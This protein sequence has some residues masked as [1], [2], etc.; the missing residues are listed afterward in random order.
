M[1][2]TLLYFASVREATGCASETIEQDEG[3]SVKAVKQWLRGRYPSLDTLV[4]TMRIAMDEEFVS[5]DA[6]L[7]DGCEIAF[8]PPV[9][10]GIGCRAA[11]THHPITS[12][13]AQEMLSIQGAG[14]VI[15]FTGVVRPTSK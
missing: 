8:I 10:G 4:T 7:T 9:S 12:A 14:A 1:K 15:T 6:H 3:A 11:L 5:D 13:A 2:V